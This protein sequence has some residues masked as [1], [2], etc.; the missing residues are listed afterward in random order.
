MINVYDGTLG[1]TI[2]KQNLIK[3][4]REYL[5]YA[6]NDNLNYEIMENKSRVICITGKNDMEKKI[7][8]F[9]HPIVFDSI[10]GE[11]CIAADFRPFMKHNLDGLMNLRNSF[12]NRYNGELMLD[13]LIF[14]KM[15]LD[16]DVIEFA[17]INTKLMMA[18]RDIIV[19]VATAVLYDGS[20]VPAVS[21][22]AEIHYATMCDK[23]KVHLQDLIHRLSANTVKDMKY[24]DW[25]HIGARLE[26]EYD[27]LAIPSRTV[28]DLIHNIRI[29]GDNPRLDGLTTDILVNPLSRSVFMPNADENAIA[30][31]ENKPTFFA[32][33]KAAITEGIN[34]K[35][36]L[37]KILMSR[38]AYIKPKETSEVLKKIVESQI[39]PI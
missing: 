8:P 6:G 12:I 13:R 26:K 18:F 29:L 39:S 3:E 23:E 25:K 37:R 24:R 16:G 17:P 19:S 4:L 36:V 14:N 1:F 7:M 38:K 30:I 21:V 20:I 35:S 11:R 15:M 10:S 28:S 27:E 22:G 34:S 5:A 31:M 32:V 33:F 9:N 2:N